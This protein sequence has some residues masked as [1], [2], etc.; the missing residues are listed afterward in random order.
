[1]QKLSEM[2]YSAGNATTA[3]NT[4]RVGKSEQEKGKAMASVSATDNT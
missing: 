1:M 2:T 3:N 4:V